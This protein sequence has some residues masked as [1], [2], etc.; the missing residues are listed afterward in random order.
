M[1]SLTKLSD[2]TINTLDSN[3]TFTHLSTI[4]KELIENSIDAKAS[5]ISIKLLKGGL[6]LIEVK[7]DGTGMNKETL[8]KLCLRFTSTKIESYNDLSSLATFGFRGEA[9]SILS[10]I[11]T[12][13]IISRD[14]NSEYGYQAV[15]INGKID[16]KNNIKS[17]VCNVG[18][19]IQV[20]NIFYNNPIRLNYYTKNKNDELEDIINTT[21]KLAFHFINISF[22][23][24]TDNNRNNV[25]ITTG[26]NN[27]NEDGN[28]IDE[29]E[30]R[31]NLANK[32]FN[33]DLSDGFF[34]FDNNE[35]D[36]NGLDK[37]NSG[38]AFNLKTINNTMKNFKF[39]C[40]H[41]KPSSY[42]K[43]SKLIVF[44]NNRLVKINSLKKIF[45]DT[46]NKFLIKKGNFF[47]YLSITCPPELL[48]VNVKANKSEVFFQNEEQLLE[49]FGNLLENVLREEINSK[50]YYAGEYKGFDTDNKKENQIL[51][52]EDKDKKNTYAK[53]KI[54]VNNKTM[55]IERYLSLKKIGSKRRPKEKEKEDDNGN[56]NTFDAIQ[57]KIEKNNQLTFANLILKE[58]YQNLFMQEEDINQLKNNKNN[59]EEENKEDDKIDIDEDE[60][61]INIVLNNI[62]K[63]G[64][65]IGF[66]KS[67]SC[68]TLQYQ[69][70]MYL[71]NTRVLLQEYFFYQLLISHNGNNS[72]VENIKLSSESFSLENLFSFISEQFTGNNKQKEHAEIMSQKIDYIKSNII[73]TAKVL[74]KGIIEF[75]ENDI[76]N[77]IKMVNFF[78]HD[79]FIIFCLDYIP[80][81]YFSIIEHIY[82][83]KEEKSN[84]Q[85]NKNINCIIDLIKIISYYYAIAY[86]DYIKNESDEYI[87]IFFRDI[88]L[89]DIQVDKHF[90]FRKK[91]QPQEI[92]EKLIDTN[93]LYTVF[94][95]C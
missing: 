27:K 25:F 21:A 89:Y 5:K 67:N 88:I 91:L 18:T 35:N 43:K 83:F 15:F 87:N 13:T 8:E 7:D 32:L 45:K 31:K 37:I 65:Y 72:F 23:L 16:K 58:I 53:D 92:Y 82:F 55:G 20:Q 29:L 14:K 73:P 17:I 33:Q 19:V 70:S 42:I 56:E 63:N 68:F 94:E 2:E 49:N 93:T 6:E 46:Y 81:I 76:I 52:D 40:Y 9:L 62:F 64:I 11:S 69:K 74:T 36:E 90:L 79:K 71:I 48:D 10:Y 4:V 75:D 22:S 50:N 47:A 80:L 78:F 85:E 30:L 61:K 60:N 44:I 57:K 95:R 3:K 51:F 39:V 24:C 41:T 86:L 77:S 59:N 84:I 34:K 54:R 66:I 28:N 12:L 38:I 1:K 26:L